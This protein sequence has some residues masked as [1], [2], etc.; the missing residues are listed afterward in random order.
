MDIYKGGEHV[1]ATEDIYYT[2]PHIDEPVLLARKGQDM[3]V[4]FRSGPLEVS[5]FQNRLLAFK[6][7]PHQI[8]LVETP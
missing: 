5:T 8:E 6:V 2:Y 1:R 7:Q 3:I 4:R